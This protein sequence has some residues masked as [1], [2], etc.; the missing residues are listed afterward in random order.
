MYN[1]YEIR[2][3]VCILTKT[4]KEREREGQKPNYAFIIFQKDI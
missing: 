1:K 4:E 3:T 2:F